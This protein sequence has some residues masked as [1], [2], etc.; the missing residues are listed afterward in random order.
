[1][2]RTPYKLLNLNKKFQN[3]CKSK[4][5]SSLNTFYQDNLLEYYYSSQCVKE[6]KL[7]VKSKQIFHFSEL[8]KNIT[9]NFEHFIFNNNDDINNDV[10]FWFLS[11]NI[12]EKEDFNKI[13]YNLILKNEFEKVKFIESQKLIDKNYNNNIFIKG[14][15]I[16]NNIKLLNWLIDNN[17]YQKD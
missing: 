9:Y 12:I 2:Y 4:N 10:I 8:K 14:A 13:F 1:M 7:K 5:I 16:T 17:F 6:E 15:I 11:L 3:I